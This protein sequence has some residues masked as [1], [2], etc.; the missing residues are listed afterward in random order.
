MY[1]RTNLNSFSEPR[2][3]PRRTLRKPRRSAMIALLCVLVAVCA[4]F[5]L[6]GVLKTLYPLRYEK[7]VEIGCQ[8]Q[9]LEKS[10]VLAV[11][12]C[13]SGFDPHAVSNVGA[14]GLMQ[15]MPE[16]F[17]WLQSKTGDSYT[18]DDLFEPAVNVRYGCYLLRILLTEFSGEQ[19][20]AVAAYHAG[21]GN[22]SKWLQDEDKSADGRTLR[23]IP[24]GST[25]AYVKKVKKVQRIYAAL[26]D[27]D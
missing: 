22:V 23:R 3:A 18:E 4:F 9:G 14:R 1:W 27:L 19:D 11:I 13:E 26:Y 8:T 5:A 7:D 24:F 17:D 10:F 16:T 15:L 6:R 25:A 2:P 21:I 12:K 20:T